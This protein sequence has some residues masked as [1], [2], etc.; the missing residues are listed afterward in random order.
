MFIIKRDGTKEEFKKSKIVNAIA[1]AFNDVKG[2]ETDLKVCSYIAGTIED[3]AKHHES[4]MGKS[5][6]IEQIQDMVE[7]ELI[8]ANQAAAVKS[9]ILYREEHKRIRDKWKPYK[10][11]KYLS[12]EFL[13]KYADN[14]NPFESEL[15]K[16]TFYITYSRFI[17]LLNRRE[18]WMEM[19]VRVVDYLIDL[20][21]T[22]SIEKAEKLFDKMYNFEVFSSG[23]IRY[24]GGTKSIK[25]NFQSAF[26]C[27]YITMDDIFNLTDA[28]YLLMLGSGVGYRILKSDVEKVQPV[29]QNVEIIHK[30]YAQVNVEERQ[31]L[32][33]TNLHNNNILE[34]VVGDSKGGWVNALR[35]YLEI[36]TNYKTS[37]ANNVVQTILF[38]YDNVRPKGERLRTFG[39]TASGHIPLKG[40][41]SGIDRI[42]RESDGRKISRSRVKLKPI[43]ILDIN[44]LIA[45]AIVVGGV[46]R[47]AEIALVSPDDYETRNAKTN[48]YT[49]VNGDWKIDKSIQHRQMSNNTVLYES[50]PNRE[51]LHEHVKTMKMSGEPKLKL[52]SI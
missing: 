41:F 15:S 1:G 24:T 14:Q 28:M 44:G 40:S 9:Y 32:T 51:D 42:V 50:K 17:E 4:I 47:A 45:E 43:D 5:F 10:K 25:R 6:T 23:R 11:F 48:L 33:T 22:G 7:S 19:N 52:G 30:D 27:S 49:Q 18:T 29:K 2:L 37:S 31:E 12:R 8:K 46:R 13:L 36:L 16:F 35:Y 26:N 39:G 21:P 20:D 38:N 34:I 3:E